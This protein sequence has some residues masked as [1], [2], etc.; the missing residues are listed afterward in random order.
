MV[1]K[2]SSIELFL[3]CNLASLLFLA[4][5]HGFFMQLVSASLSTACRELSPEKMCTGD[6]DGRC[7]SPLEEDEVEEE[8]YSPLQKDWGACLYMDP[9]PCC[10]HV[11]CSI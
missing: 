9:F 7:R 8:Q 5:L 2:E 1:R 4:W 3:P 6:S 11:L 10:M